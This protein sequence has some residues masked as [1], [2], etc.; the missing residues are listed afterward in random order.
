MKKKKFFETSSQYREASNAI[1]NNQPVTVVPCS[2]IGYYS[3]HIKF[4]SLLFAAQGR[5]DC[6]A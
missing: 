2:Q 1:L 3:S 4:G 5:S 6:L